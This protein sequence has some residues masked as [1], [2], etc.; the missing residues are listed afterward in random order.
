MITMFTML[1]FFPVIFFSLEHHL[2]GSIWLHII[3]YRNKGLSVISPT[4][5]K[6]SYSLNKIIYLL[7]SCFS[8]LIRLTFPLSSNSCSTLTFKHFWNHS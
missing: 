7:C 3:Y 1:L 8:Q 6:C 5:T 4:H 2:S